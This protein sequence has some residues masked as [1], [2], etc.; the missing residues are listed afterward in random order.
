MNGYCTCQGYHIPCQIRNGVAGGNC[1]AHIC[2]WAYIIASGSNYAF[3][4]ND[5]STA[6]KGIAKFIMNA[7]VKDEDEKKILHERSAIY[8]DKPQSKHIIK[9]STKGVRLFR[10]TKNG[11]LCFDTFSEL[12]VSLQ[13][14]VRSYDSRPITGNGR[15]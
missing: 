1:G 8:S 15:K 5:M 9:R 3:D 4:E 10:T 7:E 13:L 14:I 6:R 12:C 2:A 11:V